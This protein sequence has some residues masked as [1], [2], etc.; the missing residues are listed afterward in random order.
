VVHRVGRLIVAGHVD[1][2]ADVVKDEDAQRL[3]T[4][5]NFPSTEF[6]QPENL[7]FLS[8]N[9]YL[10]GPRPFA[11]YLDRLQSIAGD[12]PLL[13]AE[14]GIDSMREGE[15]AKAQILSGHIEIAFRAGLAGVFLFAFT[16]DWHTGGHQIESWFFGLTTRDRKPRHS[17][18]AV[19]EQYERARPEYAPHRG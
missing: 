11:N 15:E 9:V 13:L 16:D 6:L 10:H 8:F 18:H 3:V 17:F 4:F 1:E 7:D 12:K 5:T 14:F 2:L 19:A